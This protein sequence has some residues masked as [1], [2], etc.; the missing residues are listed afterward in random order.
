MT[1]STMS[2]SFAICIA[3]RSSRSQARAT[4]LLLLFLITAVPVL[5]MA[6]AV[7][8]Y[9]SARTGYL[10]QLL[11]ENPVVVIEGIG[12]EPT[13]Y[14]DR[15]LSE[16]TFSYSLRHDVFKSVTFIWE[17]FEVT[18][19]QFECKRG[20]HVSDVDE[21]LGYADMNLRTS[22]YTYRLGNIPYEARVGIHGEVIA[23]F[24]VVYIHEHFDATIFRVLVKS[25]SPG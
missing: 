1:R 9:L 5:A 12:C 14:G 13:E 10:H 8:D 21:A 16:F 23:L 4:I 19:I 7:E 15:G 24:H 2:S 11:G 25:G 20:K 6:G 17:G 18:E 22:W 3:L